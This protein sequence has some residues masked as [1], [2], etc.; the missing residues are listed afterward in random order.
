MKK[1][2]WEPQVKSKIVLEFLE[3]KMPMAEICNKYQVSHSTLLFWLKELHSNAHR[4][5]EPKK[6]DAKSIKLDKEN[7]KLKRIIAELSIELKKTELEL[8]EGGEL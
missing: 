4:I 8:N 6:T 1:R 5:F 3:Q 7:Q 2:K